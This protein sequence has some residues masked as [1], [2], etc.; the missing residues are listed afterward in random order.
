MDDS[1]DLGQRSEDCRPVV[2]TLEPVRPMMLPAPMPLKKAI[3]VPASAIKDPIDENT[4]MGCSKD[5]CGFENVVD[6]TLARNT[7]GAE[8]QKG[9]QVLRIRGRGAYPDADSGEE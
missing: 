5:V 1:H 4:I 2:A 7:P 6:V 3:E 9:V 8:N